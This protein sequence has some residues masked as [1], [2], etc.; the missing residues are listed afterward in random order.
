MGAAAPEEDHPMLLLGVENPEAGCGSEQPTHT[1][2]GPQFIHFDE[3]SAITGGF[4]DKHKFG[5]C[6]YTLQ[7]VS[8]KTPFIE[9]C[10]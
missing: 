3:L 2:D 9:V 10:L 4:Q 7:T 1:S 8:S 5:L 6:T